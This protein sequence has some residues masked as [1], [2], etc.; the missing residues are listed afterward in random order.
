MLKIGV[1]GAGHLGKIHINCIKQI[2]DFELVGFFD[3]NTEIVER[4]KSEFGIFPFE[5]FDALIDSV[6]VVDIV[7]PTF[8]H[9]EYAAYAL[10]RF[11]HVFI[12]KP[13]VTTPAEAL[14]LMD[15]AHEANVKVQVGHVE[16]F[17]PAFLAALPYFE[18][19]MFI[20]SHRLSGF[21]T[22]GID[23]PV[24]LD[25]MIH[26]IDIVLNVV[27][28]NIRKISASGV[29]VISSSADIASARLEFDNG[30]VANLTASRISL[31]TMRKSRFFQRDAYIAVDFLNKEAE[32]VRI[33]NLNGSRPDP[34]LPLLDPGNGKEARQLY[35]E[36]PVIQPIN[37]I[38]TELSSFAKA[39]LSN[40]SPPVTIMDGYQALLVSHQILDKVNNS[41]SKLQML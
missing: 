18:T 4:I 12:E 37:A 38:Q 24:I 30:C 29:S 9:F 19:P 10:K 20:E 25:L 3:T 35:F 8:A 26:D 6:D 34:L 27:K 33:K 2:P 14:Q 41:L 22:R 11:K 1:I 23:V 32:I 5:T 21:N 31:K 13:I 40:T 17:N 16:R 36:K 7:T 39:I 15:I 28:A